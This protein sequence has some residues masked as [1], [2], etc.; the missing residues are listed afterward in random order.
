MGSDG[1]DYLA[2][3]QHLHTPLLS[4][5]GSG[6]RLLAPPEACRAL[7][8]RLGGTATTFAV[9]GPDLDH[10]GLVIDPRADEHCWPLI[11]DWIAQRIS[12]PRLAS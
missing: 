11:A 6:D 7:V 10:R 3:L 5:A 12:S 4:I 1:F 2:A 9:V 8:S